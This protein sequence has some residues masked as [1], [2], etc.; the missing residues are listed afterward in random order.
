MRI[1]QGVLV[2]LVLLASIACNSSMPGS[3]GNSGSGGS[4]NPLPPPIGSTSITLVS[5]SPDSVPAGS[6]DFPITLTVTGLPATPQSAQITQQF[7]GSRRQVRP[8]S[9]WA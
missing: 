1:I 6:D 3:T 2:L 5:L 4:P 7:T 9:I 8:G